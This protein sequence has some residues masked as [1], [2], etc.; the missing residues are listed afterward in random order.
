[1]SRFFFCLFLIFTPLAAQA[2][3]EAPS[4]QEKLT[5]G[6]VLR[7]NFTEVRQIQPTDN[8]LQT[9]GH[10][11]ASVDNG[12]IWAMEKPLQ[13]STIITSKGAVQDIGGLAVKLP[14]KNLTSLYT[15]ISNAMEGNWNSLEQDFKITRAQQGSKWQMLL[16]PKEGQS[17]KKIYIAIT[18]SGG[19]FVENIVMT[20]VNNTSD[21]IAFSDVAVTTSDVP[22]QE[23]QL[24]A[25][26]NR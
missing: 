17:L 22:A 26:A 6:Q 15:M 18:V 12:L 11:I 19:R 2:A 10:F 20:K 14:I 7:G 25:K 5:A 3:V 23:K 16:T 21:E 1:M 9:S 24:Y 4:A 8:P 13:T